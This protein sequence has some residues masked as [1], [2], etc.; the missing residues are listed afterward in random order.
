MFHIFSTNDGLDATLESPD[1][2]ATSIPATSVTRRGSRITVEV[3]SIGGSFKGVI[4]SS[5]RNM[6]G[7][8]NQ[9]GATLPVVLKRAE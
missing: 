3:G 9:G 8:W 4:D 6:Q 2:S 5:R 1:Q 7:T